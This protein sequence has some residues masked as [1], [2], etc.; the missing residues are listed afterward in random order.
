[1]KYYKLTLYAWLLWTCIACQKKD[2]T[3]P[4]PTLKSI[5]FDPVFNHNS[6]YILVLGDVQEYTGNAVSLGVIDQGS[7]RY[8]NNIQI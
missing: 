2:Q 7:I 4:V 3:F 8:T 5:P 6:E 1:M